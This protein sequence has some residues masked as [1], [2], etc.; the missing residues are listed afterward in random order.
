MVIF[1]PGRVWPWFSLWWG[2]GHPERRSLLLDSAFHLG[3]W[4]EGGKRLVL[5]HDWVTYQVLTRWIL[6]WRFGCCLSFWNQFGSG[7]EEAS[8]VTQFLQSPLPPERVGI[9]WFIWSDISLWS[10]GIFP[11]VSE[12]PCSGPKDVTFKLKHCLQKLFYVEK[13]SKFPLS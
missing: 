6:R 4:G 12:P 11:S 7:R 5:S 10:I 8:G 1:H 3:Q 9:K 2:C 13:R